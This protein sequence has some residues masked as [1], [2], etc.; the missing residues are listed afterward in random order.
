[1]YGYIYKT[2]NKI[3]GEIYI[4]KKKADKFIPTYYGSG[5]KIRSDLKKYGKDS[6][7]V[8][9]LEN[10]D[11]KDE[12]NELEKRYIKNYKTKFGNKCMNIAEGG[13]GNNVHLY[14]SDAD[15]NAFSDKMYK[16]NKERCSS[17]EFKKQCSKRMSEKYKNKEEREKQSKKI[18]KSWDDEKLKSE[19]SD[20]IRKYYQTH[21]KDNSYNNKSC[22][23]VL[24]NGDTYNFDSIKELR[25]F[26]KTELNYSPDNRI[27]KKIVNDSK[28]GIPFNSIKKE[29]LNGMYIFIE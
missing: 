13:D 18:R 24:K 1:M 21:K 25:T 3:T 29:Y 6:F 2:E 27:F 5:K 20:R 9:I 15:K 22:T 28:N 10:T 19:Q 16:I 26:L 12:L 17:S 8:I 23:L 11:T 4:G 14:A 7:D